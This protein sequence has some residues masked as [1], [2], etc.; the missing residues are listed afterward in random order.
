MNSKRIFN[1]EEKQKQQQNSKPYSE[2]SLSRVQQLEQQQE[3]KQQQTCCTNFD[4]WHKVYIKSGAKQQSDLSA[5]KLKAF[6][7]LSHLDDVAAQEIAET[8]IT[9]SQLLYE[10]FQQRQLAEENTENIQQVNRNKAISCQDRRAVGTKAG[11]LI[12]KSKLRN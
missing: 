4:D 3:L 11:I 2:T 10:M 8:L 5:E 12:T 1:Q 7:G 6:P 9:F